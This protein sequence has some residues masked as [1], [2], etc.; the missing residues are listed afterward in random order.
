[1]KKLLLV[2][3]I[4][5]LFGCAQMQYQHVNQYAST[6]LPLAKS[7]EMKW[8]DY[9]KGLFTEISKAGGDGSGDL[10]SITNTL[11][12][13]SYAYENGKIT[14]EQF[15]SVQRAAMADGNKVSAQVQANN[16]QR[17]QAAYANYLRSQALQRQ[18]QPVYQ[19]PQ[20]P[21]RTNCFTNGAYTNCTSQ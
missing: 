10:M 2:C 13:A 12:D 16:A 20:M 8:S 14:K 17:A 18:S 15:E 1:M 5:T 4:S 11:I 9:Y 21:I 19:A 7:G 6:N 3:L